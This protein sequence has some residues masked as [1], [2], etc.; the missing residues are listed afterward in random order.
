MFYVF[1]GRPISCGEEENSLTKAPEN[2]G[3]YIYTNSRQ[4]R[5]GE[6]SLL[7]FLNT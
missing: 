7:V 5:K 2:P 6:E 3:F 4:K 1:W